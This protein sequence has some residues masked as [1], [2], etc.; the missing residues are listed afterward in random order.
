MLL[1]Y[2]THVTM[3]YYT[4]LCCTTRHY[5]VLHVTMLYYTTHYR[6]LHHIPLPTSVKKSGQIQP[7]SKQIS[8]GYIRYIKLG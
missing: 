7:H 1:L 2:S 6:P 4:L 5:A 8:L 3:L